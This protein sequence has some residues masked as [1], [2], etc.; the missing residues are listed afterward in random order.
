MFFCGG[1]FCLLAAVGLRHIANIR[2][3]ERAFGMEDLVLDPFSGSGTTAYAAQMLDR[4]A[5]GIEIHKPYI[6][7]AIAKRF[8]RQPICAVEWKLIAK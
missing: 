1:P 8:A 7:D 5:V 2:M 6:E 3:G 4:R